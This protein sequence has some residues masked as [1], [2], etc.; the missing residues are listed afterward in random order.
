MYFANRQ[1]GTNVL[2]KTTQKPDG[3]LSTF[4]DNCKNMVYHE[5]KR[6]GFGYGLCGGFE[7]WHTLEQ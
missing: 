1:L 7:I 3:K 6:G 2:N 5:E 4:V